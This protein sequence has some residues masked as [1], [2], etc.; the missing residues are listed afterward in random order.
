MS[1]VDADPRIHRDVEPPLFGPPAG[2]HQCMG[3]IN[4]DDA[5][6]E[7]LVKR[8]AR[9]GA[10]FVRL[11]FVHRRDLHDRK[12]RKYH[13][14][15]IGRHLAIYQWGGAVDAQAMRATGSC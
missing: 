10:P 1:G 5:E 11:P 2:K 14:A 9:N 8:G 4:L 15:R 3:F 12:H 6:L 13:K 7:I